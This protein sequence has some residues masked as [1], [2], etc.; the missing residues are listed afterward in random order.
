MSIQKAAFAGG[1]ATAAGMAATSALTSVVGGDPLVWS[2]FD[3]MFSS[4]IVGAATGLIAQMVP[5]MLAQRAQQDWVEA[6]E[7]MQSAMPSS[8]HGPLHEAKDPHEVKPPC[9][10]PSSV[11]EFMRSV[12]P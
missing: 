9:H 1:A 4:L 10:T 3:Y 5:A 2:S 7:T 8:A 11:T 6:E 12:R